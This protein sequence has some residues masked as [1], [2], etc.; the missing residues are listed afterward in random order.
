MKNYNLCIK[1]KTKN[2]PKIYT[3]FR[4]LESFKFYIKYD[5]TSK[6]IKKT[7]TFSN[8]EQ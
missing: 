6:Y 5:K 3:S 7:I 8:V 4:K 2:I 1:Y